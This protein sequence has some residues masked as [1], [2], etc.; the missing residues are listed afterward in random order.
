M[1]DQDFKRVL[2]ILMDLWD[3]AGKKAI[4]NG[5][6]NEEIVEAQKNTMN[7]FMAQL[8]EMRKVKQ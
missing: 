5:L 2:T 7:A 6:Q 3:N 8:D 1:N 4:A